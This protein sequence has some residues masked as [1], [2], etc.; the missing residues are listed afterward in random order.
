MF[1]RCEIR[2]YNKVLTT[3]FSPDGSLLAAAGF[4]GGNK[5]LIWETATYE[6]QQ[7]TTMDNTTVR[8]LVFTPDG[9]TIITGGYGK[10][11][12]IWTRTPKPR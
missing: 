8:S 2:N 6:L 1:V 7:S 11:L 3:A 9:N 12:R 10:L 4:E 5:L